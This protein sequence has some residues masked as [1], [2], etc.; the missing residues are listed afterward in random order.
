MGL[1]MSVLVG[2]LGVVELLACLRHV[3]DGLTPSL[4]PA[5]PCLSYHAEISERHTPLNTMCTY[6]HTRSNKLPKSVRHK[7]EN[8][9]EYS[10]KVRRELRSL[11]S[12]FDERTLSDCSTADIL[13]DS[14]ADSRLSLND[15]DDMRDEWNSNFGSYYRLD[16]PPC[17]GPAAHNFSVSDSDLDVNSVVQK[18]GLP[19]PKKYER[20][21]TPIPFATA[22]DE[23]WRKSRSASTSS[24]EGKNSFDYD[25]GNEVPTKN[26]FDNIS[27]ASRSAGSSLSDFNLMRSSVSPMKSVDDV[28]SISRHSSDLVQTSEI[29]RSANDTEILSQ[30]S[31][32]WDEDKERQLRNG[33]ACVV[34]TEKST[35]KDVRIDAQEVSVDERKKTKRFGTTI[36]RKRTCLKSN[37]AEISK[38]AENLNGK[39]SRRRK[40]PE[41]RKSDI[42]VQ[43]VNFDSMRDEWT[44]TSPPD[45][46]PSRSESRQSI[47]VE[48]QTSFDENISDDEDRGE[49]EEYNGI[50]VG[51]SESRRDMSSRD[52]SRKKSFRHKRFSGSV[53]ESKNVFRTRTVAPSS[54]NDEP[55]KMTQLI[56]V[57]S[58]EEAGEGDYE[59]MRNVLNIDQ[60]KSESRNCLRR[61]STQKTQSEILDDMIDE[62][63]KDAEEGMI[64]Y[65]VPE[66]GNEKAF[67]VISLKIHQKKI[68]KPKNFGNN[69]TYTNFT[70]VRSEKG[71]FHL[72]FHLSGFI[73]VSSR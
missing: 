42:S 12:H 11:D 46:D 7:L 51:L 52:N 19:A 14:R 1:L 32:I 17:E 36:L 6:S 3:S 63:F 41:R 62:E 59:N 33:D 68:V 72:Y 47:S 29:S 18:L 5:A 54:S 4:G 25:S 43:T 27:A 24:S 70:Q 49:E 53:D 38:S 2:C 44:N 16:D 40:D 50:A 64:E 73:Q 57:S 55:R 26:S 30:S 8:L 10:L 9:H 28:T 65:S 35:T 13:G 37:N 23:T 67:W 71:I 66:T 34:G 56:R 69:L 58:F 39:K 61:N 21:P 22:S 31:E 15:D 60:H 48:V 45:S 20:I